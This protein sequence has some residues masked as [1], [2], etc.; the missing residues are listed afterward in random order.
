[1]RNM[2]NLK[3]TGKLELTGKKFNRLC[4]IEEVDRDKKGTY[5]R[6]L[7]DCGRES[8][9]SG[10][11]L[12]CGKTKSC[13]CLTAEN[14]KKAKTTHGQSNSRIYRIWSQMKVRCFSKKK[15][16]YNLYGGRGI[17]I[18]PEWLDFNNFFKWAV[19]NGYKDDLSIDRINVDGNYEPENCRWATRKEQQN[20]RR[21]N[22]N[23]TLNGIEKTVSEWA[24]ELNI[25]RSALYHR[26]YRGCSEEGFLM[27]LKRGVKKHR[28]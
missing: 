24:E 26:V 7:C 8:I 18:C 11:A 6:C 21:V 25:S 9:V 2:A 3:S 22:R 16:N 20:N 23:F 13:G 17:T 4:V 19:K 27:P 28:A 12:N 1:M 5:W 15:D 14:R 10:S